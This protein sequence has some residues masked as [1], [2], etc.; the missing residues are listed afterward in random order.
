MVFR[1]SRKML[2]N[3]I[4]YKILYTLIFHPFTKAK[5]CYS[6]LL[7]YPIYFFLIKKPLE[8]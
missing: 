4:L 2:S 6:Q 1:N 7:F 3:P 5:Y 8:L